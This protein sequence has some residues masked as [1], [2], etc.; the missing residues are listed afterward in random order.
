MD[1]RIRIDMDSL[2]ELGR[3]LTEVR[4]ALRYYQTV[5]YTHLDVYKRQASS[6]ESGKITIP[7]SLKRGSTT[8]TALSIA[9]DSTPLHVQPVSVFANSVG[10]ATKDTMEKGSRW[11]NENFALLV[12]VYDAS[13]NLRD[14]GEAGET[15]TVP[16]EA[17]H[18]TIEIYRANAVSDGGAYTWSLMLEDS[19]RE[20]A[21]YQGEVTMRCV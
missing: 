18:I 19:E 11:A 1:S 6:N 15:I 8:I 4:S 2:W 21:V 20:T 14:S 10:K 3:D 13:G 7:H 16:T 5:S 9:K 12:K 17:D